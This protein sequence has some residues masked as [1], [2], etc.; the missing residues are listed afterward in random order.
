MGFGLM[1]AGLTIFVTALWTTIA[2]MIFLWHWY[3]Y[4]KFTWLALMAFASIGMIF[5]GIWLDSKGGRI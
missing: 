3:L 1:I 5:I 2:K 4:L